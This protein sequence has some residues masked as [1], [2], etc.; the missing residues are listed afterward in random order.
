MYNMQKECICKI[1]LKPHTY[2]SQKHIYRKYYLSIF[3]SQI[4]YTMS[5]PQLRQIQRYLTY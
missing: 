3:V 5:L 1:K 4:T 2:V